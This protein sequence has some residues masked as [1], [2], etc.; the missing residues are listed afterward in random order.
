MSD[1]GFIEQI[2]IFGEKGL[3]KKIIFLI[4]FSWAAL[5]YA[6]YSDYN[7]AT[8]SGNLSM[9]LFL[10]ANTYFPAKRIRI[11]YKVKNTQQFFNKYLV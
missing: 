6:L 4:L 10:L 1:K 2:P 9:I 7:L 8:G 11:K 3:K 5:L